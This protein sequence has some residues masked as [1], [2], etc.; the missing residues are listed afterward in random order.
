VLLQHLI[1]N[2]VQTGDTAAHI[3][4]VKLKGKDGVVPGDGLR[5]HMGFP[6]SAD[7]GIPRLYSQGNRRT[8]GAS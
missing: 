5:G 6:K 4:T 1:Q 8:K 7:I 2:A 3:G